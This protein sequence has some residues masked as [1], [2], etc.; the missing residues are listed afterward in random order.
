MSTIKVEK[1]KFLSQDEVI[2]ISEHYNLPIIKTH[3]LNYNEL[4]NADFKFPVVLKAVGEKIIHKSE[5]NQNLSIIQSGPI[6]PNPSEILM[7]EQIKSLF[8]E[9]QKAYDDIIIDTAPIGL[10]ADA[11]IISNY[12]HTSIF[13]IR[14]GYSLKSQTSN[15]EQ[16]YKERKLPGLGIVFNGVNMGGRFGYGYGY[17]YGYKF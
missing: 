10:V 1:N 7:S 13:V 6:P 11:Q 17:G 9:L 4:R 8:E 5:L 16:I 15:I 3:L 12:V 2:N 14:H